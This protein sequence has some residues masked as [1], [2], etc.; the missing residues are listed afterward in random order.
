MKSTSDKILIPVLGSLIIQLSVG[1]LYVWSVLREDVAFSYK[2]SDSLATMI[3][4]GML[5]GFVV[6]G[7]VGGLISDRIGPRTASFI[8]IILFVLGIGTTSILTS[9][10]IRFIFL[11]Y[12]A[13][14]GLGSGI[15]YMSAINN[16]QKWLPHRRGL[17]TGLAVSVF[18]F[19]TVIFAPIIKMLIDKF[20]DSAT[21]V[22]DFQTLFFL[23]TCVLLV[24]GLTGC[25][26]SKTPS[27]K[28]LADIPMQTNTR[29]HATTKN[30]SVR[31]VISKPTYWCLW[32]FLF[33]FTGT[34]NLLSPLIKGLGQ[35][36][37]LT[38][39]LA[40]FA[41]SLTGISNSAGR[42]VSAAI[43]DKLGRITT[44]I[45]F[46][47]V[48]LV[49]AIFMTFAT[50]AIFIIAVGLAAWAYGTPSSVM[51]ALTTDLYGPK[52]AGT[53]Y[54]IILI[55]IGI[56]SIVFNLIS[57][58]FLGGDPT[59]TFIMASISALVSIGFIIPPALQSKKNKHREGA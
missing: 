4:P 50:G 17:G 8:G 5:M 34:Y 43:S 37:G 1:I 57:T 16:V 32:L 38:L 59:K 31:E 13:M 42:F 26:L 53:N 51:A 33:C 10:S 35:D 45:I 30:Y 27:E 22:V 52:N 29:V 58:Q 18:G 49:S 15:A 23:L 54:G 20:K 6:G 28:Y 9:D 14:G 3:M 55:A 24:V 46:A 39:A 25:I 56:S 19:S 36:R 7:F 48:M 21:G 44:L 2:V 11:T 12:C 41:V 47:V 40:V